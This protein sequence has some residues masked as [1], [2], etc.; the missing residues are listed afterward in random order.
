MMEKILY[1]LF[2]LI[3]AFATISGVI[4]FPAFLY[5][6]GVA[7]FFIVC[8]LGGGKIFLNSKVFLF[9]YIIC[10]W[11]V[12][13]NNP[14]TYFRSFQRVLVFLL[15]ILTFSP[16]IATKKLL[17]RR[18]A[19]YDSL[20]IILSIYAVGSFFAYLFGINY[21]VWMDIEMDM[22][23]VGHFSG[24]TNHSMVLGPI[25]AISTI[26][27]LSKSF[28]VSQKK[29]WLLFAILG[30]LSFCAVLMSAS[31]GALIATIAGVLII[32]YRRAKRKGKIVKYGIGSFLVLLLSFPLW[33]GFASAPLQKNEANVN[34]G[35]MMSSREGKFLVRLY[36]IQEN[37]FTGVG[38]AAVDPELEEID[39]DTGR[40][41]PSN[42]WLSVFSM[43]GVFGFVL[44]VYIYFY[45]FYVARKK[46]PNIFYCDLLSGLLVFFGI[47]MFVEGY[48][49]FAGN[50][51]CG[52]FWLT[53][54]V[55][56][57]KSKEEIYLE[58]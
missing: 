4:R 58:K 11:S 45:Y 28:N 13:Y 49:L 41:E 53:L 33:G 26:F 57:A 29:T 21:F 1:L 38:F 6:S 32:V 17:T 34:R 37:F 24:L 51:L 18:I 50:L 5:L 14:P 23:N 30:L 36:E 31:R 9:F 55:I 46:I 39:K 52:M 42:S 15:V 3:F 7:L 8:I 44:Y 12:L 20:I 16:M 10:I 43:T 47:H 54:G 40:V 19:L 48:L 25:S 2:S 56:D 35:G 27:M 22:E